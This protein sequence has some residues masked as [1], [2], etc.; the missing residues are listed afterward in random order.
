MKKNV[1]CVVWD[2]DHTM[3]DGV[4]LESDEVRLKDSVKEILTELDERGILLSIASRNDETAAMAKLKEFQIDHFFLYPEISWNA[5]S[6][7]LEKISKNL[8]IHKDTLLFI[9]DQIFEREEVQAVHSDITCW[10]ASLY[11]ELLSHELLKPAFITEDAK[12]R[13]QMYLEDDRR[14]EEEERFEGPSEQFLASLNMKFSITHAEERDLQRAE[15]LT[16]RTNQLNASGKTYDYQELDFFRT[17]DSHMLLVCELEDKYGSYGKIGLSLIEE[18]DD[19]WHI[20]LL[21]MS[22]RVMSRGVGTILLGAILNEAKKQN[23][24]LYADFKQ[25]DRNRVMYVTYKFANFKEVRKE[26][27]GSI[28]FENDL[29]RIQPYPEYVDVNVQI[30]PAPAGK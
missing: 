3:W 12:R 28:L 21:L 20:K 18:K 27:D 1:K 9:D 6:V 23:K 8:N 26:A 17:S 7:S 16:V 14:K 19:E 13:R 22:C 10:D 30:T 2:L 25:T 29:T 5:K 15:E 11:K 4:L 24:K